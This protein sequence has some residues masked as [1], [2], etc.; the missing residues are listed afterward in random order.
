MCA[1]WRQP[2]ALFAP[3][4]RLV[5]VCGGVCLT[6]VLGGW[7]RRWHYIHILSTISLLPLYLTH[8]IVNHFMHSTN[9]PAC[10]VSAF[11]FCNLIKKS[12]RSSSISVN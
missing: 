4:C 12:C 5:L 10:D 2:L 11:L 7:G 9:V 6:S 8:C 3:L 1:L